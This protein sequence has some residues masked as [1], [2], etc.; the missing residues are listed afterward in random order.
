MTRSKFSRKKKYIKQKK[1]K[2]RQVKQSIGRTVCVTTLDPSYW[3][4]IDNG[5]KQNY[6]QT[7]YSNL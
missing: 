7:S 2:K 4:V 6:H 5:D 3:W 1:E